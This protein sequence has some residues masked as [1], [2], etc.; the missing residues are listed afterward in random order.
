MLR[1]RE[2]QKEEINPG[3]ESDRVLLDMCLTADRRCV[4]IF[5]SCLIENCI[6]GR[7]GSFYLCV[8]ILLS[9]SAELVEQESTQMKKCKEMC[10]YEYI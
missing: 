8:V 9:H 4:C 7:G 1:R 10:V 3:T 5:L 2:G 6:F